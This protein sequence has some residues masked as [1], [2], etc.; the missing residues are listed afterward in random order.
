MPE[1]AM[2]TGRKSPRNPS[3]KTPRLSY[4]EAGVDIDAKTRAIQRL[5]AIARGTY[6]A[7]VLS[8]IGSF[9]GL[10]DLGAAD[11][12]KHPILVT[13]TDGVGTKIKVAMKSGNHRTVGIDLVNHCVNDILVQGAIPLF[14]LDYIAMGKV[15][16]DVLVDLAGGLALGCR[17]AGCALIGGETA[18]MPELYRPG[19]YDL[20]GFIVGA[21]EK[22]H[23]IDGSRISAGDLILGLSSSGLH[24]NGYSL[25]RKIFFE[26]KRMKPGTRVPELGRTVEEELLQVHRSYLASLRDLIP[27]DGLYGMAHITGGGL[28]DNIP[29][30]LPKGLSARID[31]GAWSVPPVFQFLQREGRIVEEEMLRTFNMGI[32][33]VLVVAAHREADVVQHLAS[34]GE[35]VRR[36]GEIVPGNRKVIYAR[37]P[38]GA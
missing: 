35:A 16:P 34:A 1:T 24:T 23:L 2:A 38:T 25:A 32:G 33:M 19:E 13:S 14:F 20:A 7:G 36:I 12:F 11:R 8:D 31:L 26:R 15:N 18:E 6:R 4:K 37:E 5:K 10:Y 9:G 27:T 29:R 3:A 21:V 17:Q 28:T 30:I 22:E